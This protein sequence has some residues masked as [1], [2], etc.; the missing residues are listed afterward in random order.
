M[1]IFELLET[2][3]RIKPLYKNLAIVE[4]AKANNKTILRIPPY[5]C[6]LNP[7]ELAWSS[8]KDH[9]KMYNTTFKLPDVKNVLI[10]GIERVDAEMWKNSFRA[11]FTT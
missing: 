6:G 5:H 11:V 9:M 4:P 10:E 8:V 1:I 7:I 2:V 3:Q